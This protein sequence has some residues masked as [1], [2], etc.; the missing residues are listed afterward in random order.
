MAFTV[1]CSNKPAGQDEN[2]HNVL[3]AKRAS[4]SPWYGFQIRQSNTNKYVQLGTQFA[5]GS[6]TNTKIN[7]AGLTGSTAEYNLRILYNPTAGT[8]TFICKDLHNNT[9]AYTS[10]SLFPDI[11][12]LK[13][14]KVTIGYAMDAN[15]DPFRY[16]NIDVKNFSI[17]R[18]ADL[19]AP[20]ISCDGEEVSISCDTKDAVIYFRLNQT[21]DFVQ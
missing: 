10:N 20:E 11:E 12:D 9:Y 6:N 2:H 17:Q 15:G 5:T 19:Y 21:G 14:I 3:T 4:P 13:Y 1:D 18:L 16:S 8:N 7:P